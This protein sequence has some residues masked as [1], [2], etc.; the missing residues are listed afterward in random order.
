MK[1]VIYHLNL[2]VLSRMIFQFL[3]GLLTYQPQIKPTP[4]QKMLINNHTDANK[5]KLKG[6]LNLEDIFEFCKSSKKVT[7]NLFFHL[8]VKTADL[9]VIIYTSMADDINVTINS[10]YLIIPNLIPSAETQILFIEATQNNYKISYDEYFTERRV[11]SDLSVQH[12]IGSAQQLNSPKYMIS[13]HQ[14][15]DRIITPNKNNNIA[16]FDNLDLRKY[17][18]EIDDNDIQEM[19]YQ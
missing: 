3:K 12:D 4:H 8:I 9:Q 17:Y 7:K 11:I 19:A 16:I 6:F 2:I 14:T 1:M 10:L 13:A 5:G 15:K 18:V